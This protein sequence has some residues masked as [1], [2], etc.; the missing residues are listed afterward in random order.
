MTRAGAP[1]TLAAAIVLAL[2]HAAMAHVTVR[3]RES[4]AGAEERYFVRVPTEGA[5]ATTSVHL[6]VP[7]GVTVLEEAP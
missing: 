1:W 2:P 6:E 5:V 4:H 3:P 7:E